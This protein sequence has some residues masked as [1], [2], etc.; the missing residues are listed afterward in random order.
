MV[1]DCSLT[2]SQA[3]FSKIT[4]HVCAFANWKKKVRLILPVKRETRLVGPHLCCTNE[5]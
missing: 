1:L 2:H 5:S 3:G 4:G